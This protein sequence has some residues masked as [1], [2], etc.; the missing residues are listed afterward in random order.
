[1]KKNEELFK[2]FEDLINQ[3]KDVNERLLAISIAQERLI[4]KL[5]ADVKSK[6]EEILSLRDKLIGQK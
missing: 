4:I 2:D 5:E 1:M 6:D 3:S